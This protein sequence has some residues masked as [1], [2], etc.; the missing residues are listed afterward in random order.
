MLFHKEHNNQ[1]IRSKLNYSDDELLYDRNSINILYESIDLLEE[2]RKQFKK[3][4]PVDLERRNGMLIF[5]LVIK[6]CQ[7]AETLGAIINGF[8]L[9]NKSENPSSS[10]VLSYL[11]DYTID[12][13]KDFFKEISSQDYINLTDMHKQK[14]IYAFGYYKSDKNDI[15]KTIDQIFNRLKEI[16]GVYSFFVESYNAYKHGHRVW[17]GYDLNTQIGN[18]LF[19]IEKKKANT[20]SMN[21]V[22]LDDSVAT[23]FVLPHSKNCQKL[24][25]WILE[26]NNN[27][28]TKGRI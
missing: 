21:Y 27:M 28:R 8:E 12:Q 9:S 16:A 3:H 6:Y 5:D 26:N 10:I 14:L 2:L 4:N 17:Y 23:D 15:D 22:P 11:K 24:F 19:Y 7:Y 13:V 18:S 25:E 1:D 20:Y